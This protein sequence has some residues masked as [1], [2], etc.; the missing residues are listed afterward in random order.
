MANGRGVQA[1][2]SAL[3]TT[4]HFTRRT[5]EEGEEDAPGVDLVPMAPGAEPAAVSPAT[6]PDDLENPVCGVPPIMGN[7]A[8][9]NDPRLQVDIREDRWDMG[10]CGYVTLTNTSAE[11]IDGW[12]VQTNVEG[13]INNVW[14]VEHNGDSGLVTF[15]N[16]GWNGLIQPNGQVEFGFC[17]TL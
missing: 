10:Y 3:T 1:V 15:S 11:P 5:G 14:N 9:V 16:V 8:G 2:V 17:S 6:P 4:P 13:T 12:M 7:G